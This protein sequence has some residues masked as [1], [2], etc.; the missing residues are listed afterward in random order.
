[1]PNNSAD[2]TAALGFAHAK[3]PPTWNLLPLLTHGDSLNVTSTAKCLPRKECPVFPQSTQ[4]N[5]NSSL[6]SWTRLSA[7]P[8]TQATPLP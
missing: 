6:P 4:D 2:R 5:W 7:L 3:V 1:M 8:G